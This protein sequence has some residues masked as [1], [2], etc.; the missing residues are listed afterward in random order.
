MQ[1]KFVKITYT[2]SHPSTDPFIHTTYRW[3]ERPTDLKQYAPNYWILGIYEVSIKVTQK[4]K[5][6]KTSYII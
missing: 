6:M 4:W 1:V 5:I 3:T 2:D